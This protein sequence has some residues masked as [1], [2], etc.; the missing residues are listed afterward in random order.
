M[1]T[2][3]KYYDNGNLQSIIEYRFDCI[4]NITYFNRLGQKIRQKIY[5][6]KDL[7]LISDID[8]DVKTGEV[9][10]ALYYKNK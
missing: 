4:L 5:D 3:H 8:Y 1:D 7:E 9:R 2:N 10:K 6:S